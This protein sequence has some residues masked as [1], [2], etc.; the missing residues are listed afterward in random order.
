MYK[1]SIPTFFWSE[2]D[3]IDVYIYLFIY[4]FGPSYVQVTQR[5]DYFLATFLL[6]P[7]PPPLSLSVWM[8]SG[9]VY[10]YYIKEGKDIVDKLDSLQTVPRNRRFIRCIILLSGRSS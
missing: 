9:H 2:F 10:D 5:S 7:P 3:A 1:Y 6:P 8:R 4:L